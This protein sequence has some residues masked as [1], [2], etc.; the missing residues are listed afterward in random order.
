MT[1][2]ILGTLALGGI[3]ALDAVP[4]AQAMLSAPLV[5][6]TI[7]GLMWNDLELALAVGVVLQLLAASTMPVGSP[8]TLSPQE[9]ADLLAFLFEL[10]KFPAGQ[11]ELTPAR[12]QLESIT[13]GR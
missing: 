3:A 8:K 13:I 7:L 2:P 11:S 10:N 4:V 1:G 12:E 5:T 9:Y 6:A